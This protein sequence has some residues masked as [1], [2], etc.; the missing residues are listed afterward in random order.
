MKIFKGIILLFLTLIIWM[1]VS[2]Y[3]FCPYYYFPKPESF[4]GQQFFNPYDGL[5]PGSWYKCNF[6]AHSNSWGGL[7]NGKGSGKTV[8]NSYDSFGYS[9]HC[10]SEY[11]K[12]D[13]TFRKKEN[14]IPAY[15]HV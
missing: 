10:V 4:R 6:H 12:V 5:D 2:Q 15:E 13:T 7:T 11:Q 9:I 8:W 14:Y 1:I 3:F